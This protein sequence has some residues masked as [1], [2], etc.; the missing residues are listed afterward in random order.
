MAAGL[1]SWAAQRHIGGI[2]HPPDASVVEGQTI[3]TAL[4]SGPVT[5]L[6]PTR[7]VEVVDRPDRFGF[8]YGTLPG[9][10]YSGEERFSVDLHPDGRVRI[11]VAVDA[12]AANPVVWLASPIGTWAQRRA[13]RGYLDGLAALAEA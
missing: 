11:T 8:A 3:V 5:M 1:R 13:L 7:V 10:P 12:R 9:H 2:V 4:P 6:A